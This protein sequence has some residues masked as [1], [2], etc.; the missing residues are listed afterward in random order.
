MSHL[1][2]GRTDRRIDDGCGL[3]ELVDAEL[4]AV[5]GGNKHVSNIKWTAGAAT[6]STN[7]WVGL[8]TG[9]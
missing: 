9:K 2:K 3:R 6:E 1:G 8:M 7:W 4:S 5:T